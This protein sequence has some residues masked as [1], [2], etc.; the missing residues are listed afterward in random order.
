MIF[1]T[2]Q[3]FFVSSYEKYRDINAR[4]EFE[5]FGR[6]LPVKTPSNPHLKRATESYDNWQILPVNLF[7]QVAQYP[8]GCTGNQCIGFHIFCDQ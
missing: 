5:I 8:G 2:S 1:F 4:V 6:A 3:E 7:I